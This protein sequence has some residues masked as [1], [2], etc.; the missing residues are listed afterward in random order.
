M[1][2][3]SWAPCVVGRFSW[4][5]CRLRHLSHGAPHSKQ[6]TRGVLRLPLQEE[7]DT[8][9]AAEGE[10]DDEEEEEEE[11]E[12]EGG[13]ARRGAH[14]RSPPSPQ[15]DTSEEEAAE[16]EQED[17]LQRCG[18]PCP[19]ARPLLAPCSPR[20]GAEHLFGQGLGGCAC[21]PRA[22]RL[23]ARTWR[24]LPCEKLSDG[25]RRSAA[26]RAHPRLA[27]ASDRLAAELRAALGSRTSADDRVAVTDAGAAEAAGLRLVS[28]EEA[29]KVAWSSAA[30]VGGIMPRV[31]GRAAGGH[32]PPLLSRV[33]LAEPPIL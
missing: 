28:S 24:P 22:P 11:E 7:D 17:A 20:A 9:R 31:C 27:A 12:E 25:R 21:M 16:E 26:L 33:F 15:G 30:L 4:D 8:G 6:T 19:L 10:D 2:L 5:R 18:A 14:G 23:A 29:R 1:G 3:V 32:G 13:G